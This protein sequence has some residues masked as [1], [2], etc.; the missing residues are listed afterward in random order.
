MTNPQR[1]GKEGELKLM[2]FLNDLGLRVKRGYV[3]L[4]QSDLIGLDGIHVECKNVENLNVRKALDQA[5]EEAKKKKDGLPTVFWKKSRK[6]WITIMRA[7]DWVTLYKL[8]R[9]NYDTN[10]IDK[11]IHETE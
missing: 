8:A 10:R 9:G 6:E 2:H 4:N 7:E 11:G 3:W 1:K 5:I